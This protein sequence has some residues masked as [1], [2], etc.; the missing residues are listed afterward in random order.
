MTDSVNAAWHDRFTVAHRMM[1]VGILTVLAVLFAGLIHEK[2]ISDMDE[3]DIKA[4]RVSSLMQVMGRLAGQTKWQDALALRLAEG[5]RMLGQ[6][7]EDVRHENEKSLKLLQD[8]MLSETLREQAAR[9]SDAMQQFD[10]QV[11]EFSTA[12]ETLGLT[13]E[14]G[15]R[16]ELRAAV[17]A[18]ESRLKQIGGDQKMVSMLMMRR[19]EKDFL[20]RSDEKY[21]KKHAAEAVRFTNLLEKSKLAAADKRAFKSDLEQYR[22]G[23]KEVAKQ[24][25]L[26]KKDRK[27]FGRI[28]NEQ[29]LPGLISMDDTLE[30]ELDSARADMDAIH[31]S[32]GYVF[33]GISLALLLLIMIALWLIVR[34]VVNPLRQIS[35]AMD[36][37]DDG[38]T[39][40]H[41]NIQMQGV[42]GQ[43][44]E[45]YDKLT[46]T[47][48]E[49]FEL[50]GI[51]EASPQ[52]TMLAD[53]D[54]LIVNYM[55]PAAV[56]LFRNIEDALPCK[57]DEIVGQNIDIFHR[58]PSH[59]RQLLSTSANLPHHASFTIAGRNIEFD[60]YPIYDAAGAW[61]SV[62]VSWHDVTERSQLASNF[63]TN[64][65]G[66]VEEIQAYGNE[67][68]QAAE[69]LS[70]MAV[71]SSAQAEAV[72]GSAHQASDNVMTVASASEELSASI[73]EI[74]R[75][76]HE[77][78]QISAAAVQE[79]DS[80]NVTVTELS[81]LSEQIG[82]VVR[83][84]SEIAEQTNLLALN[85]SIEAARAGEAGRGFAVVAGEVKEL[86]N[87]TARATEQISQQIGA[88]Q[89]QSGGAAEAISHIGSVIQR[90]NEINQSVASATEQQNEATRE[91][92]QSVHFASE[93]TH[94]AS[95]DISGVSQSAEETGKAAAGVLDVANGLTQ[96]GTD[97][98]TR[99]SDFLAALRR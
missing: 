26:M 48:K 95:E 91:I 57:A 39:S 16:G 58:K 72:S 21:L 60:A 32:Q 20:L 52:A 55:N 30:K 84:I 31:Q 85:A 80:T 74:T 78:V 71:Q 68:Q 37:L 99:V 92:A 25:L 17:H 29:L 76:V 82:E 27:A 12:K 8:N 15:L 5:E 47:V 28:F 18:I 35:K 70:A 6:D 73:G 89:R 87:Q 93:A 79:A 38:D 77:A 98:S 3:V 61:Q 86:A 10:K 42:I 14:Q 41:L 22:Q 53:K 46:T 75:Q 64:V 19:H 36:A 49:A 34:S 24:R 56:E 23:L 59:Q 94:Q 54:S 44:V 81:A 4:E 96:K 90:M 11:R 83:V 51:V 69:Q 65:G 33:W 2:T 97:L 62:M 9:Q 67:M 1:L 88:I 50:K 13:A 43:L 40:I 66:V 7:Y 45:S 63:E